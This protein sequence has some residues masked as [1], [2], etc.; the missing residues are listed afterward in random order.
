L[1]SFSVPSR[2]R[3]SSRW[4]FFFKVLSFITCMCSLWG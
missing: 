1:A 2:K 3:F 4:I